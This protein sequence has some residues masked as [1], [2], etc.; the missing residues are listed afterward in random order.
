MMDFGADVKV[1]AAGMFVGSILVGFSF[2][3][4][5]ANINTI[6]C[7]KFLFSLFLCHSYHIMSLSFRTYH[8]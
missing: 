1:S 2:S 7:N 8:C 3:L 5:V 6:F 4:K